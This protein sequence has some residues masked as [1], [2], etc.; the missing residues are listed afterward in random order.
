MNDWVRDSSRPLRCLGTMQPSTIMGRNPEEQSAAREIV[1]HNLTSCG[2]VFRGRGTYNNSTP[3][4]PHIPFTLGPQLKVMQIETHCIRCAFSH[5]YMIQRV[6]YKFTTNTSALRDIVEP[7]QRNKPKITGTINIRWP[8]ICSKVFFG[9]R[10]LST[11]TLLIWF[12]SKTYKITMLNSCNSIRLL[13][14][15]ST[16]YEVRATSKKIWCTYGQHKIR[17]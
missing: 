4:P 9:A 10:T 1:G 5:L 3:S 8:P 6:M 7:L 12:H 11:P 16:F 13:Q 2:P 15:C 14:A 17:T